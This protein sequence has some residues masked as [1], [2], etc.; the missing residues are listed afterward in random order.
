MSSYKMK[1]MFSSFV[2]TL[3][4]KILIVVLSILLICF[5]MVGNI[6]TKKLTD[7]IKNNTL[8]SFQKTEHEISTLF[9]SASETITQLFVSSEISNYIHIDEQD[10]LTKIQTLIQLKKRMQQT[11]VNHF[12]FLSIINNH[13]NTAI[14]TKH[15]FLTFDKSSDVFNNLNF[16]EANKKNTLWYGNISLDHILSRETDSTNFIYISRNLNYPYVNSNNACTIIAGI[17]QKRLAHTYSHIQG[18]TNNIIIIDDEG[19]QLSGKNSL[20]FGNQLTYYDRLLRS[21]E[22]FNYSID[23]AKYRIIPYKLNEF[24]WTII[25]EVPV[26][27]YMSQANDIMRIMIFIFIVCSVVISLLCIY[28]VKRI[29][30]P[31]YILKDVMDGLSHGDLTSRF[32]YDTKITELKILGED[33][34]RMAGNINTLIEK[35]KQFL[36]QKNNLKMQALVA[37]INPH[38]IHN[39][40]NIVKWMAMIGGNDNIVNVT[41]SMTN[42]LSPAFKNKNLSWPIQEEYSFLKEYIN[43]LDI[44]FGGDITILFDVDEELFPY[45]IP[46]FIIQPL[47]ENAITHGYTTDIEFVVDVS[48]VNKDNNIQIIVQ[49]NGVGINKKEIAKLLSNTNTPS[50]YIDSNSGIGLTNIKERLEL[51]Y[52]N[53][54]IFMIDDTF[55]V[56][57]KIIIE[58]PLKGC[59]LGVIQ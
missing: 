28:Q 18:D 44:R 10:E 13:S 56:G 5:F 19:H 58:F 17:S 54:Y 30:K 40:L 51:F 32:S 41:R 55:E 2:F 24:G 50:T 34:N 29:F 7:Q 35:E 38:F 9:N 23:G 15:E 45:S 11:N 46:R 59:Y 48:V 1:D 16:S 49:D 25:N 14:L 39:T 52:K 12:D 43:I 26:K 22:S 6:I 47:I 37:Q 21:D 31:F 20:Q 4:F 36:K 33:F 53:N 42:I 27:I 57:T 8:L 3:V